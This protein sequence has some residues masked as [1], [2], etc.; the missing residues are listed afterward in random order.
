VPKQFGLPIH[1]GTEPARHGSRGYVHGLNRMD[2]AIDDHIV[3]RPVDRRAGRFQRVALA[4]EFAG[5]GPADLEARP[6]RRIPWPDAAGIATGGLFLDRKHAET[7]QRPMSCHDGRIA[8]AVHLVGH[9]LALRND[10][11]CRL[12]IGQHGRVLRNVG[13]APRAQDQPL[14]LDHGTV[15]PRQRCARLDGNSHCHVS[16]PI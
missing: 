7:I 3:K 6:P 2:D 5:D 9:R 10:E 4:A 13:C 8:P 12:G 11:P 14:G 16:I 15:D 1:G